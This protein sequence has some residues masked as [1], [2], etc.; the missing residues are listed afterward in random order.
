MRSISLLFFAAINIGAVFSFPSSRN[1]TSKTAYFQDD[2]PA[3]NNV[4]ALHISDTDG[5]LSSPVRTATGGKGFY[6]L[7]APSQ[8]SVVVSENV[9]ISPYLD[10]PIY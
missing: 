9:E 5:T 2:D 4:V 3:G 7:F 1:L 8:D 6:G 10:F